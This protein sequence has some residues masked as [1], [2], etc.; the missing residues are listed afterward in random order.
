MKLTY[1]KSFSLSLISFILLLSLS[2]SA[3]WSWQ[4]PIPQGNNFLKLRFLNAST[5]WAAGDK[6]P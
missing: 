2:T 1:M 4:H 3:Q 5:G 6:G